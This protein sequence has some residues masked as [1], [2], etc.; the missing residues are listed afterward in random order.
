[1]YVTNSLPREKY[2]STLEWARAEYARI[3]T[4]LP[5][6]GG[7]VYSLD[8]D[9]RSDLFARLL[10][11]KLPL[12]NPP[13]TS[14]NHPWYDVIEQSG[15]HGVLLGGIVPSW[16]VPG[17]GSMHY[18]GYV[19]LNECPWGVVS[20]NVAAA[21]LA[22][23]LILLK[24][25]NDRDTGHKIVALI[26][27]A[28][29]EYPEWLIRFDP[30]PPFRL[31]LGRSRRQANRKQIE[32]V[33]FFRHSMDGTRINV[34]RVIKSAAEQNEERKMRLAALRHA[35]SGYEYQPE[36]LAKRFIGRMQHADA[37]VS[38]YLEFECDAWMLEKA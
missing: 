11:G 18:L 21:K 30:W 23:A 38:D 34:L 1:M 24:R 14:F 31:Y 15:P 6:R 17:C 20:G 25:C 33:R 36:E 29:L 32:G 26:E 2:D 19:I 5:R 4:S 7:E 37:D 13:P 22:E 8:P 3:V 35:P 10:S 16:E 28:L 9:E 12:Q 27:E